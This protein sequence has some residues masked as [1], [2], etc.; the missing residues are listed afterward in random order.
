MLERVVAGRR[1]WLEDFAV[2]EEETGGTAS[3]LVLPVVLAGVRHLRP[4]EPRRVVEVVEGAEVHAVWAFEGEVGATPGLPR[5]LPHIRLD[6][7]GDP[8]AASGV[9]ILGVGDAVVVAVLVLVDPRLSGQAVAHQVSDLGVPEQIVPPAE[10]GDLTVLVR[11]RQVVLLPV[12]LAVLVE[13]GRLVAGV[14]VGTVAAL[15]GDLLPGAVGAHR[16]LA[17]DE[18]QGREDGVQEQAAIHGGLQDVGFSN[19]W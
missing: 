18:E 15:A 13:V 7:R 1:T 17:A 9:G 4:L 2:G 11:E 16:L 3:E 8:V 19:R 12:G 6:G 14:A 5:V 10:A